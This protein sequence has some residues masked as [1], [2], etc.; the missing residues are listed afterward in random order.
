MMDKTDKKLRD[1]VLF[2]LILLA[3]TIVAYVRL[4]NNP[5]VLLAGSLALTFFVAYTVILTR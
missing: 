2:L 3:V 1:D 4:N 5:A